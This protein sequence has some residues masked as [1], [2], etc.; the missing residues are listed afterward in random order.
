MMHR[1]RETTL[2]VHHTI[3][4]RT[5]GINLDA[6]KLFMSARSLDAAGMLKVSGARG[7]DAA[8]R[9][10]F[11]QRGG[12]RARPARPS[13]D[14]QIS[15]SGILAPIP[16]S[17]RG[18]RARAAELDLRRAAV[19]RLALQR[20]AA[21]YAGCRRRRSPRCSP[22]RPTPR[23]WRVGWIG[24]SIG[25]LGRAVEERSRSPDHAGG[26]WILYIRS[27]YLRMPFRL[28]VPHLAR[29]AYAGL[30]KTE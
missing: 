30:R 18:W 20:E 1:E 9:D 19:L 23:C 14:N 16:G 28:L 13:D 3:V 2:D 15:S 12:V 26:V 6:T 25:S 17:G 22:P 24:S 10:A 4:P 29:K 11:A 27:H 5:T 7:H 8:Q 21:G